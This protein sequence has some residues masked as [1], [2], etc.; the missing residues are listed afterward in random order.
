MS[1]GFADQFGDT[2]DEPVPWIEETGTSFQYTPLSTADDSIRLLELEPALSPEDPIR[3]KLIHAKRNRNHQ[4]EILSCDWQGVTTAQVPISLDGRTLDVPSEIWAALQRV[5][6]QEQ[7]RLIWTDAICID[8]KFNDRDQTSNDTERNYHLSRLPDIYHGATGLLVWLG[9]AEDN[10]DLVFEH[11][12][13]C[14]THTHINWCL[15]AGKTSLAFRH[16]SRRRWFYRAQSAQE[17]A[18]SE[19]ATILCGRHQSTWLDITKCSTFLGTTDYYHPLKGPDSVT[20]LHHLLELTRNR[21]VQ[22]RDIFLWIRHCRS[23]NLRDKVS[24][25]L[26]MDTDIRHGI[27]IDYS[28]GIVQLFQA[29][30]RKII[31]STRS[32]DVLHWLGTTQKD[33]RGLPSWVPDYTIVNPVGTLPRIFSQSATYSIH[34]PFT[35]LP[36]LDL[37]PGNILAVQGRFVEKIKKVADELQ[38]DATPGSKSFNSSLRTWEDLA[39]GISNKRFPQAIIDAF[40]DTLIG[41]DEDDLAVEDDQPPYVRRSRP[42]KSKV[43]DEFSSWYKQYGAGVLR[44]VD[45]SHT[46][47]SFD[48]P[49]QQERADRHLRWYSHHME[50]TSYGRRFF[51]TDGGSMGLAP[52]RA[53]GGDD[54]VFFPGG[55]YPFV[56]RATDR[57]DYE[58]VGDCFLYDFDVF[59]LFQDQRATTREFLLA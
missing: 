26:M 24:G 10:S 49:E 39:L 57:G 12:D 25:T 58:L 27:P 35:L 36:G 18:L 59:A 29:F 44:E 7:P 11:L 14:R 31:E 40:C 52:P 38:T 51:I 47:T 2:S 20:H 43:I 42:I 53:R 55:K 16:L 17:L 54:I 8:Q 46:T 37:R 3:C 6:L 5:R 19:K 33:I 28:R 4:Y 15:Y 30:T 34:Y 48:S 45:P 41:N 32:L 22:L 1:R 9:S 56:L 50:T 23:D 13:R 21:R